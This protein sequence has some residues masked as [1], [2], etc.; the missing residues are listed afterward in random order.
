M[1]D[2]AWLDEFPGISSETFADW[3]AYD[4]TEP[5]LIAPACPAADAAAVRGC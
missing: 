2:R 3:R 5:E 4:V 1:I